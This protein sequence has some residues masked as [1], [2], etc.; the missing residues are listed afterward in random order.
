MTHANGAQLTVRQKL[1]LAAVNLPA[2]F[3]AEDLVVCAWQRF[4]ESFALRGYEA[5][6]P[7]ANRVL[8]K[9][10]GPDGLCGLGWCEQTELRTYRITEK[11][12]AVAGQLASTPAHAPV[13]PAQPALAPPPSPRAAPTTAPVSTPK[14]VVPVPSMARAPSAATALPARPASTA[15]QLSTDDVA[16][17]V[18]LA[19][20]NA[21]Q[22]FLRGSAPSFEDARFFWGLWREPLRVRDRLDEVEGALERAVESHAAPG[23]PDPRLPP[24]ATCYGLLSLHRQMRGRFERD[25][26]ALAARSNA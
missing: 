12:E 7:D 23:G 10:A 18:A 25:L 11:G 16:S 21:L 1:L 17:L 4:P 24:L 2:P 9:L 3:V 15:P 5:H 26:A 19:R 8:A 13:A 22:R 20:G 6:Y 14:R